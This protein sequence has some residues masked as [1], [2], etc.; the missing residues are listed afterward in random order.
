MTRLLAA[1]RRANL[2]QPLFKA[3]VI[4][5][6]MIKREKFVLSQ[7]GRFLSNRYQVSFFETGLNLVSLGM[8]RGRADNMQLDPIR[9]GHQGANLVTG[10]EMQGAGLVR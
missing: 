7:G 1:V 9:L 6:R 2:T 5:Y 3:V 4:A 10:L 8:R